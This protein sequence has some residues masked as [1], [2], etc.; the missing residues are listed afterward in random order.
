MDKSF[1]GVNGSPTATGKGWLT[2]SK[3]AAM[4]TKPTGMPLAV[5]SQPRLVALFDPA[6]V[7]GERFRLLAARLGYFK[8]HRGLKKV[9][10]TSAVP[11]EGKSLISA[12][13]AI[14]LAR[15]H[16]TLLIDGDLRQPGLR[17]LLGTRDL[18]GL[19]DWWHGGSSVS[20]FLWK[21]EEV[22]LWHLP[23]G[24][25]AEDPMEILQSQRIADMLDEVSDSFDWVII[26]SPP[27][28]PVADASIW[29]G[30]ADGTLLV[31]RQGTTPKKSLQ[32]IM[33]NSENLK[34]FGS[35]MNAAEE[36]HQQYYS[37]YYGRLR[38]ESD[39]RQQ[40]TLRPQVSSPKQISQ[41]Q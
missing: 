17:D 36:A 21:M 26:D 7:G 18:C 10:I 34:L 22:S 11:G 5:P 28:V 33:E 6:C 23:A 29:A 38:T 1:Q 3:G 15:R 4:T 27:L 19:I 13:L 30:H 14:S 35:V 31:V 41:R 8:E 9:V 37:H 12:N 25:I 32:S 39:P 20:E 40:A 24:Q 16:R 2:P